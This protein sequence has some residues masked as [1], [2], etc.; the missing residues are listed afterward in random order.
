MASFWLKK[1]VS[2]WLMPMSFSVLAM[3]VGVVLTRS[4]K[5][6]R[7]GR[8][9]LI[10]GLLLLLLFSNK[11]VAKWLLRPLETRYAP[12]PEF[13]AGAPVPAE[14][15]ACRFV[16]VLGGGHGT[17]PGMASTTRLST[18]AL[19]R[20]TE[21]VRILRALPDA[22]LI[23][24]GPGD[25]KRETHAVVLGK[26]A[27]SLGVAPERILYIDQA[28]DTEDESRE[29]KKLVHGARVAV[30]TSAWHMPRS[31]ALMRS[32]GVEAVACPADFVTHADDSFYFDNVFWTPDA[33]GTSTRAFS[34][35]IGY[36]W[37]WLRGKA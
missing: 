29:V 27:Q 12:M 25:A 2:F 11:Y 6:A 28:H 33:L 4:A 13:V 21:A 16:Y 5:R 31:M 24:S 1:F 32:A 9:L 35:R 30:V 26:A 19:G 17:T 14:L 22:K 10:S 20:I 37:I 15:A 23:V 18:A 7:L 36:L 34:E 8:A 3:I